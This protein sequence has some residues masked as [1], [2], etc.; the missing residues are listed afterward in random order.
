MK[1]FNLHKFLRDNPLTRQT[2]TLSKGKINEAF[3]GFG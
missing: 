3:D 1:D 2:K